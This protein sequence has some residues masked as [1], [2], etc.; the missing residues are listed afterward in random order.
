MPR[1]TI[2]V[3]TGDTGDCHGS[4]HQCTSTEHSRHQL[5]W[6][7]TSKLKLLQVIIYFCHKDI[8]TRNIQRKA[9]LK[10][11]CYIYTLKKKKK[12]QKTKRKRK[13]LFMHIPLQL[14]N[15]DFFI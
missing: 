2:N 11:D 9:F 14:Q 15:G 7:K 8:I 4:E 13:K 1:C 6:S 3:S 5:S 12:R 10:A